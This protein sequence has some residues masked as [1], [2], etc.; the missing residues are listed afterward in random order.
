MRFIN[1]IYR[2]RAKTVFVLLA[3]Y[4]NLITVT[5]LHYH[6][7]DFS[8]SVINKIENSDKTNVK[9]AVS[10]LQCP[11]YNFSFSVFQFFVSEERT[12]SLTDSQIF[13]GKVQQTSP[14]LLNYNFQSL[15]A[16]PSFI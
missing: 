12:V 8:V 4:L 10:A 14:L 15:R 6:S 9:S 3:V 11:V 2:K 13:I 5:A 1:N 7:F 16:P